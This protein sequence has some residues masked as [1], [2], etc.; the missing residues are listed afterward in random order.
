MRWPR[1]AL[2]ARPDAGGRFRWRTAARSHVGLVRRI[3]EDACL[4]R[5][6]RGLWAVADGMGGHAIGDLA[7]RTV[8][9]ALDAIPPAAGLAPRV[10][11][12]RARLHAANRWLRREAVARKVPI[13]GSTVVVLVAYGAE[14]A[15]LWAGDS[16]LYLH[17]GGRLR[18]LTC[19]H[20][21][22]APAGAHPPRASAVTRAVGAVDALDLDAATVDVHDGD[23][24]VLCSDGLSDAVS[25]GEIAS[26]VVPGDCARAAD[27]LVTLALARGGQDN[28]SAVVVRA[29][30]LHGERTLLNPAL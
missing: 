17:R 10:A 4:V 14:C 20:R 18:R 29:E 30:D 24:L 21:L 13:I 25:D 22:A 9:A 1:L 12:A 28:I 26:A 16:R 2:G 23:I 8:V 3:N 5:P 6:E 19:D 27:A 15:C 7:S 11:A